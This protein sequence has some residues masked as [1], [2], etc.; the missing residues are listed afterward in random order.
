MPTN[1]RG[2]GPD[3]LIERLKAQAAAVAD[4]RTVAYESDGLTPDVQEQFWQNVV[5]FETASSTD[6]TRELKAIGVK[7]LEPDDL[8]D[9]AL[10]KARWS[11]IEG[12]ARL[13]VFLDQTDHLSDR[14]LYTQL[15]RELLPQEMPA[16]DVDEISA[17]HIDVLGYDK[18]ELYLK[19][20]ADE[21]TRESWR[22]D[23]PDDLIP[24]REDPP[25]DRDRHLPQYHCRWRLDH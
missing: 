8:D 10:R 18:P 25:Y 22:I 4:G 17:W 21:K 15:L 20:Y 14:E 5:A 16:L 11:I 13:R 12:L 1:D 3:E 6:L 7:L 24:G 23:F 19:Y 2:N 9:V